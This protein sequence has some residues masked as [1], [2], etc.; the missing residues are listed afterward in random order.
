MEVGAVEEARPAPAKDAAVAAEGAFTVL[1]D[2]AL[3]PV[4]EA[5]RVLAGAAKAAPDPEPASP[6]HA[7]NNRKTGARIA[8][9]DLTVDGEDFRTNFPY[10]LMTWSKL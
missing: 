4:E 8:T 2:V 1:V 3:E 7:D 6:P 5:L 10:V 9:L